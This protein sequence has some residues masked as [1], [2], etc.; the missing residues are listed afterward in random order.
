[1]GGEWSY[2]GAKF[3]RII[4]IK[5]VLIQSGLLCIKMLIVIPKKTTEEV[6]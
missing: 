3:V 2:I 1:M 4:D 5:L 6:D